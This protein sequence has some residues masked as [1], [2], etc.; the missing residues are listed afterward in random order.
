MLPTAPQA[1]QLPKNS[2]FASPR[3]FTVSKGIRNLG[4]K[5]A[6]GEHEIENTAMT[7]PGKTSSSFPQ[8]PFPCLLVYGLREKPKSP[9]NWF[10]NL[11]NAFESGKRRGT[12]SPGFFFLVEVF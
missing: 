6:W 10:L 1:N 12:C 8:P 5:L 3:L 11:F 2:V 7:V 4:M 9:Q